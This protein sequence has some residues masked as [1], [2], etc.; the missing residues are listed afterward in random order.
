MEYG[1]VLQTLD[2]GY[3]TGMALEW[4]E[5]T[6][7]TSAQPEQ[8][9]GIRRCWGDGQGACLNWSHQVDADAKSSAIHAFAQD[10]WRFTDNLTVNYGLRWD[11][12]TIADASGRKL[13]TIDGSF[14]PQDDGYLT[15]GA[16][17]YALVKDKGHLDPFP[18]ARRRP[19]RAKPGCAVTQMHYAKR[20]IDSCSI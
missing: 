20:G 10:Q 15:E 2:Y 8:L 19:L 3:G 16:R 7:A 6:T 9:V 5:A 12:Q 4:S 18:G 11:S 14:S 1:V 13:I 17:E